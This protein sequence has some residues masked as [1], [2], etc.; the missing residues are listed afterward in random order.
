MDASTTVKKV[1]A[2]TENPGAHLFRAVVD[3]ENEIIDRDE[4]NNDRAITF[5]AL[6]F[7][8]EKIIWSPVNLS[9]DNKVHFSVTIKNQSGESSGSSIVDL[10]INGA[11]MDEENVSATVCVRLSVRYGPCYTGSKNQLR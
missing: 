6:D 3:S 1:F 4:H 7:V 2:W 5:P 11:S 9:K 8:L 10:Y